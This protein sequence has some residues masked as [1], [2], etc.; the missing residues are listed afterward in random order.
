MLERVC[1][2]ES[3][4]ADKARVDALGA[5]FAEYGRARGWRVDVFPVEASGDVVTLTMNEGAK[6]EPIS[7]S[8]HLDTVFPVGLF[9]TPAVSRDDK[10]MYG[11]G[12][13][14]CKGGVIVG[15]L[16]MAALD[17]LGYR[18]RPIRMLLQTDEEKGSTPSEKKTI[19][20]ICET[21]LGS[22]AFINLEGNGTG[23][24]IIVT[25]K[26]IARYLLS[27]H[28]KAAH[29]SRRH[30]GASAILEASHKI[31]ALEGASAPM[32]D[33][34][35][36]NCGVIEGGTVANSVAAECRVQVDVRYVT[37][38]QR[39]ELDAFVREIAA[40][41]FV[42]GTETEVAL[43][44][45]RPAT[46]LCEKNL[47]LFS[48]INEILTKAGFPAYGQKHCLGGTDMAYVTQYGIPCTD[49]FGVIGGSEHSVKEYMVLDSLALMAKQV[50]LLIKNL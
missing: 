13:T 37:A 9:G 36:Y 11:P 26:G 50:A 29:S 7:L 28:G 4:T 21:A 18:E 8:G 47:A 10:N 27:I 20:H 34:I 17:D 43:I 45:D 16:A 46:E 30:L 35:T 3:P 48:R 5:Y 1:N 44:S 33:G 38:A 23:K 31:I 19:R 6:G 14:D 15:I 32:G 24:E 25:T 49:A 41:V 22:R 42:E 40:R 2:M 39:E 12:V